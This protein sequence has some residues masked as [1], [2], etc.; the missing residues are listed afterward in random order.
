MTPAAARA[1]R[2][3]PRRRYDVLIA[4]VATAADTAA[5]LAAGRP[6]W[7][8]AGGVGLALLALGAVALSVRQRAPLP[9]LGV[10]LVVQLVTGFLA[11]MPDSFGLTTAVALYTVARLLPTRTVALAAGATT[12]VQVV[13]SVQGDEQLA[14][15]GLA[16]VVSVALVVAVGI[17]VR[18]WQRQR[19]LNEQLL[20][21]RAV[22]DERRRIARELHDIVAHHITTMYLMSGGAR[23]TLESDPAAARE[24]LVTLE[25]SG[26]TALGEMRQ[27]LGVLRAPGPPEGEPWAPQPGVADLPALVAE[28]SAAGRP[29]ELEI[30]GGER[31]L[32]LPVSLALYRVVQ[33]ALTNVRKHAGEART[34]VR[35]GYLPDGVAVEIADDGSS[36][37]SVGAFGGGGAGGYGLLGMRERMAVHGGTLEAGRREGGGFRVA[38]S[39]PLPVP[40]GSNGEAGRNATD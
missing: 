28:A 32:P 37:G 27:L 26:R 24:A 3:V 39:V 31:S 15:R 13:R 12:A 16:S 23:A 4:C 5:W 33:E 2:A 36:A 25:E 8:L 11:P 17:G 14:A 34:V 29:T 6:S 9:V 19:D 20:A 7:P 38:A 22:T 18:N 30:T 1:P 40:D 35:L 21:D 10:V